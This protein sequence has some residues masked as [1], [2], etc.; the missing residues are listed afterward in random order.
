MCRLEYD[1]AGRTSLLGG[2]TL[3]DFGDHGQPTLRILTNA[4]SETAALS[5]QYHLEGL[6]AATLAGKV[7]LL[8]WIGRA[9]RGDRGRPRPGGG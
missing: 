8:R 9:A 3:G 4:K 2:A 1:A 7:E 6:A 5:L